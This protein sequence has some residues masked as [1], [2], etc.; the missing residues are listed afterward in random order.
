MD[1]FDFAVTTT[2][3]DMIKKDVL[4]KLIDVSAEMM[5][6]GLNAVQQVNMDA[7]D[8]R[9]DIP[10][11]IYFE[12]TKQAEGATGRKKALEFFK[13]REHMEKYD[14]GFTF[15]YEVRATQLGNAQI[16]MSINRSARG[17]AWTRDTEIFSTLNAAA[18]SSITATDEWDVQG[19]TADPAYDIAKAIGTILENE[20]I[21]T[22]DMKNIAVF[23]PVGLFTHLVRPI[24]INNIIMSTRGW[25]E[26]E[27]N[28]KFHPTK[29][30]TSEA[31]V[32]LKSPETALHMN[33][34]GSAI[35]RSFIEMTTEGE[36][37]T[38]KDYFKTIIVP[39]EENGTTTNRILKIN[40]V[41]TVA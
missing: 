5:M 11:A 26:K 30:L 19:S 15:P 22:S 10:N 38:F 21:N 41:K 33:Y 39:E 16:A 31:L 40:G 27:Y 4:R 8:I 7:L 3:T 14:T 2:D 35:P 34:N 20:Y 29:Q 37:Y 6:T 32:V 12:T 17:L 36:A 23:Y 13:V 28:I 1:K 9:L 24:E 18:G 25:T